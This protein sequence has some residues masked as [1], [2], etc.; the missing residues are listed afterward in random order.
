MGLVSLGRRMIFSLRV[1]Q[2]PTVEEA[3]Q[4]PPHVLRCV[5]LSP[6]DAFQ[7]KVFGSSKLQ[8]A[9][10]GQA[11]HKTLTELQQHRQWLPNYCSKG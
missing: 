11:V 5:V 2:A 8:K 9:A 3:A 1:W 4:G 10:T 6:C 7:T